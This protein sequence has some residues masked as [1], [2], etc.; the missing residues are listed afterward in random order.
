MLCGGECQKSILSTSKVN[1]SCVC[2]TVNCS[3]YSYY[4]WSI[5]EPGKTGTP[6]I[7]LTDDPEAQV[8]NCDKHTCLKLALERIITKIFNHYVYPLEITDGIRATFKA[9]LWR[10]GKGSQH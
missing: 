5:S 1:R 9:K 3:V 8:V 10:M 7:D 4:L 2:T 6:S